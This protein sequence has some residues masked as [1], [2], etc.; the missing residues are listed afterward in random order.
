MK[1]VSSKLLFQG[2]HG[3]PD[4]NNK[5]R[6]HMPSLFV[7]VWNCALILT[8][9]YSTVDRSCSTRLLTCPVPLVCCPFL[10]HSSVR[11]VRSESS[12]L[13]LRICLARV[14]RPLRY[15]SLHMRSL[16]HY[17]CMRSLSHY[18]ASWCR[19]PADRSNACLLHSMCLTPLNGN[20]WSANHWMTVVLSN[21]CCH[22]AGNFWLHQSGDGHRKVLYKSVDG[23]RKVILLKSTISQAMSTGKSSGWS[24]VASYSIIYIC[25]LTERLSFTVL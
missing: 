2:D 4:G 18:C 13:Y 19:L 15:A 14:R 7:C 16:A 6:R 5:F 12:L 24:I 9:H 23:L 8:S 3:V 1:V 17:A 22:S 11:I 20:V 21:C 10:F 25:H